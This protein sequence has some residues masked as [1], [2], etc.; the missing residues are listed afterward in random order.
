MVQGEAL[1]HDCLPV[2][3]FIWQSVW[4]RVW[5]AAWPS[6]CQAAWALPSK[7]VRTA[8]P[9]MQVVQVVPTVQILQ[10]VPE[11]T[12]GLVTEPAAPGIGKAGHMGCVL[13]SEGRSRGR[14]QGPDLLLAQRIRRG[15]ATTGAGRATWVA[16]SSGTEQDELHMGH[17]RQGLCLETA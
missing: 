12:A 16:T 5:N 1:G 2:C 9:I 11:Q 14:E 4:K 6:V 13:R 10:A 15:L 8:S 7:P 3:Q 17:S